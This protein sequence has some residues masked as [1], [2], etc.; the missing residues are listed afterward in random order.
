MV[1][2]TAGATDLATLRARTVADLTTVRGAFADALDRIATIGDALGELY[3]AR[4]PPLA[5]HCAG[6]QRP[7]R[8]GTTRRARDPGVMMTTTPTSTDPTWYA[9]ASEWVLGV[10][11]VI[12]AVLALWRRVESSLAAWLADRADA[13]IKLLEAGQRPARRTRGI[14]GRDPR[15]RLVD[16]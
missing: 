1:P 3:A 15:P 5:G 8:A 7:D 11:I 6:I 2:T 12:A 10:G 14:P 4:A 9:T 13:R 16:P